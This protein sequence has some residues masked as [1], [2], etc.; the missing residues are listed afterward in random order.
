MLFLF[1]ERLLKPVKL[2]YL[3]AFILS[4]ENRKMKP[5]KRK[6]LKKLSHQPNPFKVDA[7]TTTTT[8]FQGSVCTHY[9]VVQPRP[10]SQPSYSYATTYPIR[11]QSSIFSDIKDLEFFRDSCWPIYYLMR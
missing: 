8:T 2:L 3:Q 11:L 4:F 10:Q 6:K 7:T 9:P 5:R 1:R